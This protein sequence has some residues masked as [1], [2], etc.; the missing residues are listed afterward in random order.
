MDLFIVLFAIIYSLKLLLDTYIMR[1]NINKLSLLKAAGFSL[2]INTT[3]TLLFIVSSALMIL[4]SFILIIEAKIRI[5][6][7]FLG[8][9]LELSSLILYIG[10][11]LIVRFIVFGLCN[12]SGSKQ[13]FVI[14]SI[15]TIM[16]ALA[17]LLL[18]FHMA[19]LVNM[20]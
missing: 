12:L 16:F 1:S 4:F 17:V 8:I 15:I 13:F 2:V 3:T 5:G 20:F 14:S 6:D 9:A 7:N 10:L 11:E 18:V 19:H